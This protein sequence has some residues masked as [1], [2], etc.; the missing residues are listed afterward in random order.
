MMP[1]DPVA[2]NAIAGDLEIRPFR[3]ADRAGVTALWRAT[4]DIPPHNDPDRDI[5]FCRL[6]GHGEVLVASRLNET[7]GAVMVGHD[8]HRGWVYY[9]AVHPPWRRQ[10]LGGKLMAAA[11]AWLAERGAPKVNLLVRP[12]NGAVQAF[13]ERLGF[14]VEPRLN[15]GKTLGSAPG[16]LEVI[17]TY[18]EMTRQPVAPPPPRPVAPLAILRAETIG[19]AYYRYLYDAVGRPWRWHER[20]RMTDA[21]LAAI[22][23]DPKVEIYV[24]YCAG[25]PAG[26]AELDRRREGE[27]ELAYFGLAPAHIGRGFGPWF[28]HAALGAAW[29]GAPRR[30]WVH[31]CS[32]DHPKALVLYQRAGFSPYRQETSAIA[33]PG[34]YLGA[35]SSG[36]ESGS[37]TA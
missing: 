21:E 36:R 6:S 12:G 1:P 3:E 28:L 30:V 4:L 10:G 26:Y 13:Y 5:D 27:V 29:T 15:L 11:E 2:P 8:G 22:V 17:V 23:Q 18:L 25:A 20:R 24:L 7:V 16:P 32:L 14:A 35:S 34:P 19:V 31:S 33:D 37:R 9:L